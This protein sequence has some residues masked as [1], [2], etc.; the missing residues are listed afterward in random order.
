MRGIKLFI[1]KVTTLT[2]KSYR[3]LTRCFSLR[4]QARGG[5]VPVVVGGRPLEVAE[6]QEDKGILCPISWSGGGS[7]DP[8]GTDPAVSA[9]SGGEE[10]SPA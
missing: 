3:R 4:W 2:L 6:L 5:V 9:G 8:G 7:G 1:R 10:Q